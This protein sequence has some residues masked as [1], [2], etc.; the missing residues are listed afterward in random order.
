MINLTEKPFY[1]SKSQ[2][3]TI[4]S[5]IDQMSIDEKIEQLFF[6][7]MYNSNVH[8]INSMS[9][10]YQFGGVMFRSDVA[11][12]NQEAINLLQSKAKTPMFIAA[13]LEDGGNGV[14]YEGSYMGRQMLVAATEDTTQAYRLGKICGAE[15][16]AVGVNVSFSPVVDIDLN[17]RNPITN[18]RTFGSSPDLVLEMS[19]AYVSGLQEEGVMATIKHFPGDGVDERDQHLLTSV[20]NQSIEEWERTFGNLYRALIDEG[21]FSVMVGHI[22]MPA[23]EEYLDEKPCT[24]V[25][26]SSISKNVVTG[27]LRNK[28]GFNGLVITDASP[29]VGLTSVTERKKAVPMAIENGC[30]MFLFTKD[31]D[32]DIAYM[33][34][35]YEEGR[36]S[37]TRL[38]EA[39]QRI[40]AMKMSMGLI[41][42]NEIPRR[43]KGK[44]DLAVLNN[45]T[46]QQWVKECADLGVTLVKDT[47][48]LLPIKPN[49]HKNVLLQILGDF[50]SNDRVY[51]QFAQLLEQEGFT[52]TKYEPETLE[53]IFINGKVEDFKAAYDLVMY[54]GN[55][56]NASNKTVSRIHWHTLFGAGNNIPWFAAEVPTLFVSVGNPYHLFD[57]PMIKTY[58]NGYCHAPT[59]IETIVENLVG[60]KAF[61]GKSP[62]DPFCGN[63]DTQI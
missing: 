47:Q 56:E 5:Y 38:I 48:Q 45:A 34:L 42:E 33:K 20:N 12:S 60:R 10:R 62:I 35:G 6:P 49:V 9:E 1:L 26:P 14:A 57:V 17:F 21:V 59:V 28:L 37:D 19:R 7:L 63:W 31:L 30:D 50:A 61:N 41:S 40:L 25:I 58:I 23:M 52:I 11:E 36:L 44:E 4:H 24:T 46:H 22:A 13:N 54:I 27:F 32:E 3:E 39:L 51:N 16:E 8:Y 55:I 29:M 53:T 15:G 18:V 43:K 2:I